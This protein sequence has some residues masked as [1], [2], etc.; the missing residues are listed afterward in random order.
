MGERSMVVFV[1]TYGLWIA[2]AFVFITM[3]WFGRGCCGRS[4]IRRESQP[5]RRDLGQTSGVEKPAEVPSKSTR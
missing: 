5:T 3:H 4:D 1:Q 2:L